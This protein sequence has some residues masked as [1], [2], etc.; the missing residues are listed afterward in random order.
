MPYCLQQAIQRA[1]ELQLLTGLK[2][3]F[4]G[5]EA[6]VRKLQTE[7]QAFSGLYSRRTDVQLREQISS[8]PCAKNAGHNHTAQL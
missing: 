4:D 3:D 2:P 5:I 7:S 8:S 1:F 6:K